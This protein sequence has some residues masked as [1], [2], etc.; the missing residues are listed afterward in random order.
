[1]LPRPN[2][3]STLKHHTH[4]IFFPF[5][6]LFALLYWGGKMTNLLCA[7]WR[8]IDIVVQ[9]MGHDEAKQSQNGYVFFSKL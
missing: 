8:V 5:F 7:V 1:M 6:F 2:R 3:R 9:S 4:T